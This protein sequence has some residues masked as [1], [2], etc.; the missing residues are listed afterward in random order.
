MSKIGFSLATA[1]LKILASGLRDGKI[2]NHGVLEG[3][4]AGLESIVTE[5]T[6]NQVQALGNLTGQLFEDPEETAPEVSSE[7]PAS[8]GEVP[9]SQPEPSEAGTPAES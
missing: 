6:D 4:V 8:E 3:L 1:A 7:E 9:P 5:P 2:T